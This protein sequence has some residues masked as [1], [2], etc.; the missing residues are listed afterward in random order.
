[1]VAVWSRNPT[2]L[3]EATSGTDD[4]R[5]KLIDLYTRHGDQF[6]P[7]PGRD[8][9]LRVRV[10]GSESKRQPGRPLPHDP[11]PADDAAPDRA[12]L[13][14][15]RRSTPRLALRRVRPSAGE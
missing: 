8:A 2:R 10:E 1:V 7:G 4:T 5:D 3:G 15:T 13:Q 11:G 14:D 6:T 12:P 9:T